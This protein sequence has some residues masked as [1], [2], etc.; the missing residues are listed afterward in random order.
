MLAARIAGSASSLRTSPIMFSSPR[1]RSTG[2][3]MSAHEIPR[4]VE[5]IGIRAC[6]SCVHGRPNDTNPNS[7]SVS[8]VTIRVSAG[9]AS[10]NTRNTVVLPEPCTPVVAADSWASTA[11]VPSR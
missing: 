11:A 7:K 1:V 3:I 6:I 8:T 5:V 9:Y 2:A 4:D 10:G